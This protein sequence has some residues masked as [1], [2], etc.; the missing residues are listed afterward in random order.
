MKESE[1]LR[2]KRQIVQ[3]QYVQ[4]QYSPDARCL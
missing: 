3:W 4:W 1:F 2:G